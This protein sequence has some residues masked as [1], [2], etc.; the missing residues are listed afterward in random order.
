MGG[1]AVKGGG[2]K[3]ELLPKQAKKVPEK[4]TRRKTK[5]TAGVKLHDASGNAK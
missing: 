2:G 3:V 5:S 1:K 4:K